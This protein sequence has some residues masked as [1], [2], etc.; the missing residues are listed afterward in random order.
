MPFL[1]E[2]IEKMKTLY[3]KLVLGAL[4]LGA[5][6][7]S[8]AQK[9]DAKSKQLLDGV[10]EFYK[11]KKN[12]YFK[13]NFGTGAN[14]KVSKTETGIYYMTPSQYKLKIMGVEQIFDGSK[15]YNISDED[16][17]VT[18]AKATNSEVMFS[19]TAYLDSYKKEYNTSY[20]G[21]RKVGNVN[22]DLIKLVPISSNG[23]SSVF[24]YVNAAKKQIVKLEQYGTDKSVSVIA[25]N[26]YK[27]NQNLS[28]GTFSFDKNEYKNYLITEL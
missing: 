27:E 9:V 25:I 12:N 4:V 24:I 10:A 14:G 19:P 13:F 23:I 6:G 22:T 17:E 28:A 8:F 26:D 20:V 15:L 11:S 21:K 5:S 1:R 7:T 18:I 2:K 3:S 16:K